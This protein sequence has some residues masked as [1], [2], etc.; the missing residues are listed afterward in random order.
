MNVHHSGGTIGWRGIY[1]IFPETGDG[2]CMLM[3]GEAANDLW[4]PIVRQWREGL[5]A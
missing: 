4:I 5:G 3:N 2:V 1:S